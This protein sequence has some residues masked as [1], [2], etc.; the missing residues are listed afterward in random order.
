LGEKTHLETVF[1]DVVFILAMDRISY[2]RMHTLHQPMT[3][4]LT[5]S[6]MPQGLH[7]AALDAAAQFSGTDARTGIKGMS[8][9]P[10]IIAGPLLDVQ[11][12]DVF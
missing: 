11:P 1:A 12:L 5:V 7:G 2:V 9:A 3:A 10:E 4:T 8:V 6:Y